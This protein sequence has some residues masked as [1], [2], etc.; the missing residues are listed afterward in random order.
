M[1]VIRQYTSEVSAEAP[2]PGR[3]PERL[4]ATAADFGGDQG[5][6]NLARSFDSVSSAANKIEQANQSAE[7][8]DLEAQFAKQRS[9]WTLD[10]ANR[11]SNAAPGDDVTTGFMQDVNNSLSDIQSKIK[12]AGGQQYFN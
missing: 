12:T 11:S 5:L 3:S 10:L 2:L 4:Y 6:G 8:S 9:Q 1:P 7:I